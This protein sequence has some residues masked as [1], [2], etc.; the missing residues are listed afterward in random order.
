[1]FFNVAALSLLP[2]A[3][4]APLLAPRT[5]TT[6]PGKYLV[7][8]KP[9]KA[10]TAGIMS[11]LSEGALAG[12]TQHHTYELGDFK[13]FAATLTDA[14]VEALKA[15]DQVNFVINRAYSRLQSN[16]FKGRL[17]G[18]RWPCAYYGL[19]KRCYLGSG[20]H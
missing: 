10:S 6:V 17:F 1:M 13:G 20:S 12:V 11:S 16:T 8:L 7:V 3:L 14:Q 9:S 19:R 5:G 2:L 15:D 4:G 18:S